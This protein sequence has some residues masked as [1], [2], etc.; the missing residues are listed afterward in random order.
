MC[1]IERLLTESMSSSTSRWIST[2]YHYRVLMVSILRMAETAGRGVDMAQAFCRQS[3][4]LANPAC[5]TRCWVCQRNP[6]QRCLTTRL[7]QH[8][9]S[10]T[11]SI[12]HG[13]CIDSQVCVSLVLLALEH[14]A[15]HSV[16]NPSLFSM[17]KYRDCKTRYREPSSYPG[18]G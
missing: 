8:I 13:G 3:G 6:D 11:V 9:R 5:W 17:C 2:Q 16:S 14:N 7:G 12:P 10:T 18:S 4:D 15:A 1:S